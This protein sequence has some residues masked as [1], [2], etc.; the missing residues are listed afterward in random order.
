MNFKNI[1]KNNKI[2][3][4]ESREDFPI[5]IRQMGY[6]R[7]CEVGVHKGVFLSVLSMADPDH[8][9]GVDVWDKYD[10]EAYSHHPDHYHKVYPHDMNK[11]WR[12]DVQKWAKDVYFK[13]DIIVDFSVEAAK[14]FEDG[15][16]DFI[17]ID[18]NHTYEGVTADLESWYPKVRKGGM[19]AG[20]DYLNYGWDGKK[21]TMYCREGVDD[22]VKKHN[23]EKDIMLTG[24]KKWKS[25]YFIK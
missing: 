22:F 13:T 3:I 21:I 11:V 12:E 10:E 7:I 23:K 17:Y 25:F 19:I 24:E 16:F 6:K 1:A 9:V 8:L 5:L 15:Y 18:A 14:Q 20:H 2:P 4:L